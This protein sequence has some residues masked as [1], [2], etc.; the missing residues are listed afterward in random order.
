MPLLRQSIYAQN[1]DIFFAPT[2]HATE[3]WVPLMQTMGIEGCVF[4]MTATPYVRANQLPGWITEAAERGEEVV[5]RG[6]SMI[7]SPTGAIL[8][9]PCWDQDDQILVAEIDVCEGSRM[10]RDREQAGYSLRHAAFTLT[11]AGLELD[12]TLMV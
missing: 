6:G 7:V 1:I 3:V 9:G 2:A 12:K 10:R 8:A 5:S 11:T 4:V